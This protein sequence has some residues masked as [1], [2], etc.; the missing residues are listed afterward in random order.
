MSSA[1]VSTRLP[2]LAAST[3]VRPPKG[4]HPATRATITHYETGVRY[5]EYVHGPDEAELVERAGRRSTTE[6]K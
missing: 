3:A 2:P 6:A 5:L 1:T 4:R